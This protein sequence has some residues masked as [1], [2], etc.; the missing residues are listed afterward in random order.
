MALKYP[1]RTYMTWSIGLL[2]GPIEVNG[3]F[4]LFLIKLFRSSTLTLP[5]H[6]TVAM[7]YQPAVQLPARVCPHAIAIVCFVHVESLAG[8]EAAN[9]I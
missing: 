7:G 6:M 4:T 1:I 2:H 9:L 8:H 3:V 5:V